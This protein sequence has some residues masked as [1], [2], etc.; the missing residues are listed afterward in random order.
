VPR[1]PLPPARRPVVFL[2]G[3]ASPPGPPPSPPRRSPVLGTAVVVHDLLAQ[4]QLRRLVVIGDRARGLTVE[5]ELDRLH[6]ARA[7]VVATAD[8]DPVARDRTGLNPRHQPPPY[9]LHSFPPIDRAP[10]R[11][12][13]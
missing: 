1:L 6:P 3:D 10:A 7:L 12:V 5:P 13:V 9:P 8:A 11:D 4:M 2:H